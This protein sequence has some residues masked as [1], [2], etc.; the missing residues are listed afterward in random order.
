M[1]SSSCIITGLGSAFGSGA[2]GSIFGSFF[3]SGVVGTSAETAETSETASISGI[4]NWHNFSVTFF[5]RL[6]LSLLDNS[7]R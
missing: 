3:G 4:L 1:R 7:T 6:T 2:F 5:N